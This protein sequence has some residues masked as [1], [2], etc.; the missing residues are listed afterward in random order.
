[1]PEQWGRGHGLLNI[2][3]ASR[4][5]TLLPIGSALF[6]SLSLKIPFSLYLCCL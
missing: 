1:M 6:T 4:L 5:F 3:N 2:D